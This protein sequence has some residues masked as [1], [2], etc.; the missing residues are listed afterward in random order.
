MAMILGRKLFNGVV[1]LETDTN[2]TTAGGT[3]APVGSYAAA[4]DGSGLFI[5]TGAGDSDWAALG[6][7]T[8]TIDT[9]GDTFLRTEFNPGADSDRITMRVG[10]NSGDFDVSSPIFDASAPVGVLIQPAGETTGGN[11]T[12]LMEITGA[13]GYYEGGLTRIQGG[14]ADL[15][16]QGPAGNV[17]V[18]GGTAFDGGNVR[19]EGGE[20]QGASGSGGGVVILASPGG[21]SETSGANVRIQGSQSSFLDQEGG[22]IEL[23]AGQGFVSQ[24]GGD[25]FIAGG[26][27]AVGAEGGSVLI[28]A[29]DTVGAGTQGR[30]VIQ[31]VTN[32]TGETG[33][34]AFEENDNSPSMVGFRAPLS[35]PADFIWRLPAT[36][37]SANQALITDGSGNL[38]F[39]AAV[40]TTDLQGAYDNS[41]ATDRTVV[42]NGAASEGVNI[43]DNAT[44]IGSNLFEVTDNAGTTEF[45]S[46]DASGVT[47]TGKLTVTGMIDPPGLTMSESA[48]NPGAVA[49]GDGTV[50]VRNDAPNVLMYTDDAGTD[51]VIG[52]LASVEPLSTTL[53]AGNTTGGTDLE[54]SSGD[55][56]VAEAGATAVTTGSTLN[57]RGGVAGADAAGGSVDIRASNGG[58]GTGGAGGAFIGI[59]GNAT[60][61]N[62]QG[63]AML[64]VAGNSDG[65]ANGA[66]AQLRGGF[67]G[68]VNGVGGD[69]GVLGGNGLAGGSGT[70][71]EATLAGGDGGTA[72][73]DGGRAIVRGGTGAM[74]GAGGGILITAGV[75]AGTGAG[76]DIDI[77]A[78][79]AGG[80]GGFAGGSITLTP[81][82]G[83]GA[84]ADGQVLVDGDARVTG[85]LVVE[86]TTTSVESETVRIADNHLYLNDG[87]TTASAQTGGLVVN[88]LPSGT[89][90]SVDT[91]GFTAGVAATSNPT[92]EYS[93]FGLFTPGQFIQISGSANPDNDGLYELLSASP[94]TITIRGIG[95]TGTVE[96]FTKNQFV[97][98][99]TVQGTIT[100]VSV[101][102]IRAGTGGAWESAAGNA[103]PLSFGNL[104]TTTTPTTSWLLGGNTVGSEQ[105]IGTN[106]A[107]DF[108]VETS[109]TE[110]VRVNATTGDLTLQGDTIN[111]PSNVAI[112]QSTSIGSGEGIVIGDG[113]TGTSGRPL[114]IGRAAVVSGALNSESIAIGSGASIAGTSGGNNIAIGRGA[115][116]TGSGNSTV[117]G[118]SATSSALAGTA[119]GPVSSA[120]GERGICIGSFSSATATA[121]VALGWNADSTHTESVAL[122][123]DSTTTTTNQFMVGGSTAELNTFING[124]L[125]LSSSV[126]ATSSVATFTT[127]GANGDSV[128][129]FVGDID[130]SAGGGVAAPVGSVFHRDSGGAGTTGE[131]WLKTGAANTAWSLV[132]TGDITETLQE[133]YE[134]GNTIVTDSTNG[135]F[136]VSGTEAV[137]LDAQAASNFTVDGANLTLSTTTGGDVNVTAADEIA[138][139]SSAVVNIFSGGI[140]VSATGGN[141]AISSSVLTLVDGDG[142]VEINSSGGDLEIGNDADTGSLNVGT[143]AAAR[144]IT[145]GNTTGATAVN[146]DAGT[147]DINLNA[148]TVVTG[149][150]TVTG[151]I[152][153]PGLQ[154]TESAANP[155]TVAAGN[156]TLWL[157]NDA[158]NT[159]MFTDDDGTDF[160]V[161]GAFSGLASTLAVGNFTGGTPLVVSNGDAING[162]TA[163]TGSNA[164]G[165]TTQIRGGFGDGTGRGGALF[166]SGGFPGA[167]GQGGPISIQGSD[168]SDGT[169]GPVIIR[170]GNGGGASGAAGFLTLIGGTSQGST[171]GGS[172]SVNGGNNA[173]SGDGGEAGLVAGGSGPNGGNGGLCTVGGGFVGNTSGNGGSVQI[174]GAAGPAPAGTGRGG[175][176]TVTAGAGGATSG[177]GGVITLT[178]GSATSG[179]GGHILL[180]PGS[181]TTSPGTVGIGSFDPAV[182]LYVGGTGGTRVPTGTTGQ[183]P[184]TPPAGTVRL[185]TTTDQFEG[186]NGTT[187]SPLGLMPPVVFKP[188]DNE[189]PSSGAASS[190]T[191]NAHPVLTFSAGLDEDAVFAGLM[192]PTFKTGNVQVRLIWAITGSTA[193]SVSWEVFFERWELGLTTLTTDSF[194]TGTSISAGVPSTLNELV[195]SL[196]PLPDINGTLPGEAFRLRVRR[197]GSGDS[198]PGFAALAKVIVE[199]I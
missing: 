184:S 52:G 46:V 142:G 156:G 152:D 140:D 27:G 28:R 90:L 12:P 98:D 119:I 41:T 179:A 130:P 26:V 87:Y 112:G 20:A 83:D 38:S 131:L 197:N 44:P 67:G 74:S 60:G 13:F 75:P 47:V 5:K 4:A 61:G 178:G 134:A 77:T 185:N 53:V 143:G 157:R 8:E 21:A 151:M 187:W 45:L 56:I 148:D 40:G 121:S 125:T 195:L 16:Y 25:I 88:Y 33:I 129:V 7:A 9:D 96:D 170:P 37:G 165:G 124:T 146:V 198:A 97:T 139:S 72:G 117:I 32:V 189:P 103:T 71:G 168:A 79:P 17:E 162:E 115:T 111:M 164:N 64:L 109:G 49:A 173:D 114:A 186:Y 194:G 133:A 85:N 19:I 199:E 171:Q 101:S 145:I 63:G 1:A 107:F 175:D 196:V 99:T 34:L 81:G 150:L 78:S 3:T 30:I 6:R 73:G 24:D 136:D 86:G 50:W 180:S 100:P 149:K 36:D 135:D 113:A 89:V 51:F 144:T 29:G 190:S 169:G 167:S 154:M 54:V 65:T 128:E 22:D 191:I 84:G 14:P 161:S 172:A 126:G 166:L 182:E 42:L 181:G 2:P 43:R 92:V 163:A 18:L 31:R 160:V 68:V 123:R 11:P 23:F 95:V 59:A 62:Q 127:T 35:V 48:S 57:L 102:V 159:L 118:D 94:S 58:S 177:D 110:R 193:G 10:D 137:S 80:G 15:G 192:P 153:P 106:D 105:R 108:V 91:G 158:P 104:I 188:Q 70:G 116:V 69:A 93:G 39:G 176:V 183:R 155:G 122:G 76:A 174:L 138:I 55:S 66:T 132:G 141:V 82:S 147:G 120:S